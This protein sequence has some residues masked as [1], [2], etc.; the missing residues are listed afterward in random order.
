[1][2]QDPRNVSHFREQYGSAPEGDFVATVAHPVLLDLQSGG[3]VDT[4]VLR[5][6]TQVIRE[7]S[8]A[9]RVDYVS[10][11][12]GTA[13][14]IP[15]DQQHRTAFESIV[16]VGRA[17]NNDIVLRYP[18]ISKFH[19][20]FQRVREGKYVLVDA[21]STNGTFLNSSE[22][23]PEE[24]VEPQDGDLISFGGEAHFV[25]YTPAGFYQFLK[26]AVHGG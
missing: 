14:V 4:E 10:L 23:S 18:E 11:V 17:D 15:V 12:A 5:F 26:G 19:A 20:F 24:R 9:G 3:E 25:F 22:L 21:E 7:K 6:T 1:M 8:A 13:H 2:V 16:S